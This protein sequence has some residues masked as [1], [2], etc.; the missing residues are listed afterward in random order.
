MKRQEKSLIHQAATDNKLHK[1]QSSG[2][3]IVPVDQSLRETGVLRGS[4]GLGW[5]PS[6]ILNG[7][8]RLDIERGTD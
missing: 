1:Q 4:G 6:P 8:V 5:V 7:P 3:E 2:R